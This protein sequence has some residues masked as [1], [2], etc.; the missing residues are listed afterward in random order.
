LEFDVRKKRKKNKKKK[1]P[2]MKTQKKK[3][4]KRE[5]GGGGIFFWHIKKRVLFG[6]KALGLMSGGERKRA[7]RA[8]RETLKHQAQEK[9]RV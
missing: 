1:R 2:R 7:T 3:V 8:H 4:F 9:G 5:K 6:K